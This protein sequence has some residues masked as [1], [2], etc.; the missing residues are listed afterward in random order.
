MKQQTL[1]GVKR[2]LEGAMEGE[3]MEQL[4]AG[5]YR[6]TETRRGYRNGY[7][8]RSLLTELGML[9]H[10]RVP[11]DREGRYQTEVLPRYQ[12]RQE[13][14]NRMVRQMFL[15]GVSTRKVT[16]VL[17]PLLGASMSAQTVS[18]I[19]RSLDAEV[20]RYQSRPLEDKYLYLLLD[21]IVLK[22][23]TATGVVRRLVLCAYGITPGGHREMISFRQSN[24]ESEAQWEAFL[25][26]LYD[27]GLRGGPLALV[28]TDGCSGLHQALATVYPY[29]PRQRCWAH[30]MRNVAARLPRKIQAVC[31]AEAK[32]IYQAR[33][34]R[35]A[36]TRF[37]QWAADW[38]QTAPNAVKCIE[39][40][41]E[42][43]LPFLDCPQQHWKKV[44]TTNA[45]ERS[46]REVRR[47]T[48][49]MSCFQ[50][51]ASVDRIVYGVFSH[52]N[53]S[54]KEKPI[55]QFTHNS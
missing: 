31:L 48:R 29:V 14:V 20:R 15:T 36:I 28:S 40:D 24:S 35:E 25:R 18:R 22:V 47:R 13:G 8:E 44:R 11:R 1:R 46:F 5:R 21:G 45:I 49:P 9:E 6:R 12:R 32:T 53:N 34:R 23:K 43:L 51:S 52:L 30:K 37:R 54:W 41:L 39:D 4:H 17:E 50:N 26:D 2:L 27:R 19:T 10:L 42:E 3:L 16:E 7:R 33:T 55:T 38:R